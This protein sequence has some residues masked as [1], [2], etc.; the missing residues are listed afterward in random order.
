MSFSLTPRIVLAMIIV[1][2]L[3]FTSKELT[4][5]QEH[6]YLAN[7]NHT[8][9]FWSGDPQTYVNVALNEIDY[10][11]D[12]ADATDNLAPPYQSR[13]NLDG[14]WYAYDYKQHR[15]PEQF[16][17]LMSR[18]RSGHISIP[19]NFFVST[20]G[21]QPTE[22]ILRGMY[23]Q[24]QLDREH[25][26]NIS[27]AVAMENQTL[28]L[29]LSSLWAGS[30]AKY[31][32]KGVCGC[33]SPVTRDLLENRNHEIYNYQGLDG[34][35]LVM[36]W[37]SL[38]PGGSR[39][40]GGYAEATAPYIAVADCEAKSN[41]PAY[42]YSITGA[43]GYGWDDLESLTNTF[44]QAAQDESN[45]NR[46]VYVS[47]EHDFFEHF[48][49]TY[50]ASSLPVETA[51]YGND[52]D[53][54]CEALAAVTANVRRS[55]EKLR[56]AEALASVVSVVD[57][58][59]YAAS[60]PQREAAWIA[61]GSFWEH[62]FGLGG[63]C[64]GGRGAWE[65][66]LEQQISGY[67]DG[68]FENSLAALATKVEN[69]SSNSRFIAFNALG[70]VRSS[71]VD[72]AYD[73]GPDIKVVDVHTGLEAPHEL[74]TLNGS[75]YLR[76][77]AENIPSVGYK[78][79]EIRQE[80]GTSYPNAAALQG[81]IFENS[82]YRLT[83]TSQ[84]VITSLIDKMNGN[85]ELVAPTNGRYL[86]DFGQGNAEGGTLTLLHNGPVSAT[87]SC[88]SPNPLQHTTLITLYAGIDRIDI[89][90]QINDN[91]GDNIRTYSFS[92][93]FQNPTLRHEEL[94]S[95]LKAKY[96]SNGGNYAGP[97]QP[98]RHDWQTLNHFADIGTDSRGVVLSN[99]GAGFMKLGNSSLNFLDENS[100]QVNVLIGGRMGGSG[101]GFANQ[102][103]QTEFRNSFALRTRSSAFDG[104]AAMRFA[105]EHQ[106][107]LV[108]RAID[109]QDGNLP[110]D[111]FS[112]LSM[113]DPNVLLWALKPAE[114][115]VADG[116]L[117]LRMW[118]LDG[119]GHANTVTFTG[120][121]F[122]AQ[123]TTHLETDIEPAVIQQGKLVATI[124]QQ[125]METFRV[126][127]DTVATNCSVQTMLDQSICEGE[128]FEGYSET[129]TFVD[130][131]TATGGC[132]SV[133]T[134]NLTVLPTA[135]TTLNESICA[136]ESYDGYMET[137]VYTDTY[138][139][140]NGC[141]SVRVLN[142]TVLPTAI[143]TLNESICAGESYDGYME[144]GVY[145]DTY[146]AANGC[147]SVRVLNL[148]VLPTASTILNESICAGESYNGYMET[149]AYTDTYTAA[150]GC[151]SVRVLNLTV[152]PTA[153]TILNESICAGESY[154]GYME[155]GAYTDTYTGPMA[156]T[157]SGC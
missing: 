7:D 96:I 40:L 120:E 59:F 2:A 16:E 34:S 26:L 85:Q 100:A 79:Y 148:T 116:G 70:W 23:W 41:T 97:G 92:F 47:N 29:G 138:T 11:L 38:S 82:F 121:A 142:L 62:N 110:P 36:K 37:Y 137:G 101:P 93:D 118:N 133:R 6:I 136:G 130:I 152:L 155:P 78:V 156:A 113:S 88:T 89:D 45:S 125:K 21:G 55:V 74:F 43:F 99:Q 117:I 65:Q 135:I 71:F 126:F 32:W 123:R 105:L 3:A 122:N 51:T 90:N 115:G 1:L 30:G 91:F 50:D 54:D 141:D 80:T 146:T 86:N 75:Q 129:G 145:T 39:R 24:G 131:F 153:S 12:Q 98:I 67:V 64:S 33:A 119:Q 56:T 72:V 44:V 107:P 8:D 46:Q 111:S 154:D 76:I 22:A 60:D 102:F 15:T 94:G 157:A 5:Q 83:V 140:A 134:L 19:Y 139:A 31:S 35:G 28:P 52:W 144:T 81:N 49:S 103:G 58:N 66:G 48:L 53:M 108:G 14:A 20:Y 69:S 9:Y 68:L 151:D 95:V 114:E 106:N 27:M 128:S 4:A 42:P 13:Y 147:D 57:E 124:G 17:R 84:G 104:S 10:Y 127:L 149:G 25:S 63:C 77:L 87:L 18:I 143:T 61:L 132:D 73:G 150:N 109:T 112:L